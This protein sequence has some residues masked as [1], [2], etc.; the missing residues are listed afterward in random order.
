[1]YF[2]Q[3]IVY[4]SILNNS[5]FRV[6]SRSDS[7]RNP[8]NPI[9]YLFILMIFGAKTL[10]L[11]GDKRGKTG[12]ILPLV[13]FG[14]VKIIFCCADWGDKHTADRAAIVKKHFYRFFRND[15]CF[16]SELKPIFG[17]I[18]GFPLWR[19]FFTQH[20]KESTLI[21]QTIHFSSFSESYLG[22]PITLSFSA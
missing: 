17:F 14:F 1:M 7:G 12:L 21:R 15:L 19:S 5:S 20:G 10:S 13:L 18:T 6:F 8:R 11:K 3:V 2:A 22:R 4:H 16:L 9:S